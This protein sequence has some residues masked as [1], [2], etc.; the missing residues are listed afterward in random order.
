MNLS[1]NS[2]RSIF[3]LTLGILAAS[4]A[5]LSA[6]T[7]NIPDE[8]LASALR[9][10]LNLAEGDEITRSRLESIYTL[11]I[12]S[13]LISDITG[14]GAAKNLIYLKASNNGISD[15]SEL[16]N[17]T[18]LHFL[19][20]SQNNLVVD[21]SPLRALTKLNTL[22]ISGTKIR[23][24]GFLGPIA[25]AQAQS[26]GQYA[27]ERIYFTK[28]FLDRKDYGTMDISVLSRFP[29]LNT[30]HAEN[31]RI[32]SLA[33]IAQLANETKVLK[34]LNVAGNFIGSLN[35]LIPSGDKTSSLEWLDISRA[36]LTSLNG[37]DPAK[38]PHLT[39]INV[40]NNHLQMEDDSI[41]KGIVDDFEDVEG[42]NAIYLP[43][44]ANIWVS[45]P[46]YGTSDLG[47]LVQNLTLFPG[48]D[49][50]Y[51]FKSTENW[52]FS[53][54][55]GFIYFLETPQV[56]TG[57]LVYF[58]DIEKWVWIDV[59]NTP[60]GNGTIYTFNSDGSIS[61]HFGTLPKLDSDATAE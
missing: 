7:V 6:E 57:Y 15:I 32:G 27:L 47:T 39:Y 52:I 51:R 33:S 3:W 58:Y 31:N 26:G 24:I 53:F 50:Q 54:N 9:K 37:F 23:G 8:K 42:N 11:D 14:L 59:Y 46:M 34:N 56:S 4:S 17:L 2:I 35:E 22:S 29:K 21:G 41:D 61:E 28:F 1:K 19:D 12:S 38:F 5:V 43:Q 60:F 30:I 40:S 36:Y 10:S 16:G 18:E 20:I 13:L 49:Y 44:R 45:E 55:Y 25:D 48:D